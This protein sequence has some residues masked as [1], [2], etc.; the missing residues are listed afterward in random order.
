MKFGYIVR[1]RDI[2][3]EFL[4]FSRPRGAIEFVQSEFPESSFIDEF[5]EGTKSISEVNTRKV[6]SILNKESFIFLA[7]PQIEIIREPIQD[8]VPRS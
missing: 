4:I 5:G 6:I 7:G 8:K 2:D 3:D 1:G